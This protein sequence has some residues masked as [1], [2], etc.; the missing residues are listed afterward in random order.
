MNTP[1]TGVAAGL[2]RRK[3]ASVSNP[4]R[5]LYVLFAVVCVVITAV[6]F[7]QFYLHGRAYPNH[8]IPPP[9][10]TVLVAHGLSMTAWIVLFLV[11]PLLVAMGN[12]GLHRSVGKLGG[13]LAA[14]IVPLG[15]YVPIATARVEPDV[16]LWGLHRLNF[17]A[18][19][20]AS[21][22]L[23]GGFVAI[24]IWQRRRP[25]I[26]RAMMVL[27]TL[28]VLAAPLDR[29]TGLSDLYATT[30]WGRWFGPFFMPLVLGAL[31]LAVRGAL[32][33]SFDRWFA[34]GFAV[35]IAAWALV[36]AVAPTAMWGHVARFLVG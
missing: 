14:I 5:W 22:L 33:R 3:A 29:I 23:F 8:E 20:I 24:A 32:T 9:V 31:F 35:Q 7:Q 21:A 15:L 26:H 6:G 18:V 19:P 25:A 30:V 27:A 4:A 10:K 36:I 34:A 2:V 28:S 12:R 13:V 11:Q 17:T 16:V 1:T